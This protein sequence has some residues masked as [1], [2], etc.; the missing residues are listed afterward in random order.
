MIKMVPDGEDNVFSWDPIG[1]SKKLRKKNGF[2]DQVGVKGNVS[3]NI[4]YV[5]IWPAKMGVAVSV[6]YLQEHMQ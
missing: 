4:Q 1:F 3:Q 2:Q 6:S 5:V